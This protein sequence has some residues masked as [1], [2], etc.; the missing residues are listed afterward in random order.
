MKW[1]RSGPKRPFAA[2][3]LT[4]WQLMQEVVSKT[5]LPAITFVVLNGGLLLCA[6]PR[7]KIRGPVHGNAQQHL[8]V[9]R[10][11]ILRALAEIDSRT[12]RV[13]PHLVHAIRNQVGL[14]AQLRDPEAV[15]GVGRQQLQECGRGMRG[16]AHRNVQ[17][18]CRDDAEL[19][20]PELPP[21]LMADD[22]DV[23]SRRPALGHPGSR[24]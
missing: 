10:A 23:E 14:A 21:E 12:R 18:V 9:L 1:A 24:G 4:A 3:P 19:R 7:G 13:D 5:R 2:V 15:V 20:I 16:I 11:A 22:G 8:G 6:D 17:F